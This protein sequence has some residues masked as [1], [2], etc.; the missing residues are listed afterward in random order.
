MHRQLLGRFAY[1]ALLWFVTATVQAQDVSA[2]CDRAC[3]RQLLDNY[4]TAVFKH[5]PSAA[6]QADD[7]Y[8]TDD[9]VAI[10]DGEGFWKNVSGYG[11][12]QGRYFDPVNETAAFLGLLKKDGQ[13]TI[14]SVRIRVSGRKISEAEWI[15]G[16]LGMGG[17]GDA[18]PQ[19][20]VKYPPPNEPLLPSQRS[21]RF[22][23]IALAN[24]Y[25]QANKNHD[26]SWLPNDPG[27]VR[28]EN[29]I[30]PRA[31]TPPNSA[32]GQ[33]GASMASGCLSGFS[34][35]DRATTDFALRRFTV[36]DEEVGMILGT[37]VYVRYAGTG[38]RDNLVSEYFLI[39][40]GKIHAIWSAMH[41]LPLGA[42]VL[43]G[44]EQRHGIW[45]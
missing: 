12:A 43:T 11:G 3:L 27:C 2:A 4:L 26:A 18:D 24:N 7:H 6:G 22:L 45:R 28:V 17:I 9:T 8:A 13:D 34:V 35:M 44:W 33:G 37:G 29:G 14:T 36:V 39:R 23:M 10:S 31:A 40:D 1:G 38:R 42:P 16:Q 15:T 41:F 21:S 25:F 30:G 5:D 19:G 20:L 32:P